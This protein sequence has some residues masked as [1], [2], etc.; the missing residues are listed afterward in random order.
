MEKNKW[1]YLVLGILI[2][3]VSMNFIVSPD[4][5]R[6]QDDVSLQEEANK[7][8][9]MKFEELTFEKKDVTA[10]VLLLADNY[11]QHNPGIP[12]GKE[13]FVNGV[14]GYL[15]KQNPNLIL[16]RKRIIAED[17]LVVVHSFGKFDST[18][19]TE[20][21]VAVID[22]FRIENGKIVEHWDVVQPIP[23]QSANSN[24]MF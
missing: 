3:A 5:K 9:V 13:G 19:Q 11:K 17:D 7:A 22:I 8:L 6:E 16:Q 10:A 15:L 21:G 20:R 23:E 2:G 1:G 14:G 24:T 18:S 4:D 12:D